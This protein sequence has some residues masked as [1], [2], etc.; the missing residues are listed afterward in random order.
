MRLVEAL[1]QGSTVIA[2]WSDTGTGILTLSGTATVVSGITYTLTVS[3]TINGV[4]FAPA[5]ITKTP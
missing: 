3:G 4:P 5:S 1:K 2:S